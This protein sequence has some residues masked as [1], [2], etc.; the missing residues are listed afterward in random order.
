MAGPNCFYRLGG[1]GARERPAGISAAG[2]RLGQP[3]EAW[4]AAEA[5]RGVPVVITGGPPGFE[6]DGRVRARRSAQAH[7]EPRPAPANGRRPEETLGG[8]QETKGAP[9]PR[10]KAPP[11]PQGARGVATQRPH[12]DG[13]NRADAYVIDDWR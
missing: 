4:I 2:Q 8:G 10:Q 11:E 13:F 5:F 9:I 6:K 3:S 7:R 12:A 1:Y